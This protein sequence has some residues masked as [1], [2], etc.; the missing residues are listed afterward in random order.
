[1]TS[2]WMEIFLP[3][4][5]M[6]IFA[7]N[8]PNSRGPIEVQRTEFDALLQK[9]RVLAGVV[10]EVTPTSALLKVGQYTLT[11][12]SFPGLETGQKLLLQVTGEQTQNGALLKVLNGTGTQVP[13]LLH[14]LRSVVAAD[15]PVGELLQQLGR[16]LAALANGQGA[17]TSSLVSRLAS[18]VFQPGQTGSQLMQLLQ[19]GGLNFE[20]LLLKAAA[21]GVTGDDVR[22]LLLDLKAELLSQLEKLGAG[23]AREAIARALS[24]LEAEQLLN[25]ARRESGEPLHFSF[26]VPDSGE[27]TTAHLLWTERHDGDDE[28]G[29]GEEEEVQRISLGIN[30]SKTGPIRVDAWLRSDSLNLKITLEREEVA[31]VLRK[32]LDPLVAALQKI[33]RP[34]QIIVGVGPAEE[35][36]IE[37]HTM[38]ISYLRNH[39]LMD[40]SA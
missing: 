6:E 18:H 30:F 26:A 10:T 37:S 4:G 35:V 38:D 19:Q 24:G 23:P 21:R 25:V 11:S 29:E 14:A 15:R 3:H 39:H 5:S 28:N 36:D 9:G 20:A 27:W 33:D 7:T 1:M 31:D 34:V 22:L 40:L 2:L 8:L 32:Q 13:G 16:K 12:G 17:T